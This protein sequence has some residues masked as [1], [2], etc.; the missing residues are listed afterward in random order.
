MKSTKPRG[1]KIDFTIPGMFPLIENG[2]KHITIRKHRKN[3]LEVGGILKVY[4][5]NRFHGGQ[6]YLGTAE[7]L[8]L[9]EI[10][11]HSDEH[12]FLPSGT[13]LSVSLYSQDAESFVWMSINEVEAL[14]RSDGFDFA[15]DFIRYHG[16]SDQ[17]IRKQIITFGNQSW[18][19]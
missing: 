3:D 12:V 5:G 17:Q 13:S 15:Y 11:F 14:A 18:L 19:N 16:K 2:A 1:G 4:L 6:R 9:D 10:C 7:I 8:A